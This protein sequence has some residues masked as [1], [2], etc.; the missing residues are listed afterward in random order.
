[1]R[2]RST[3]V[4]NSENASGQVVHFYDIE[5]RLS[6][7]ILSDL[8]YKETDLKARNLWQTVQTPQTTNYRAFVAFSRGLD[9]KDRGDYA[10]ARSQFQTALINDTNFELA[11]RE[12][13]HTPLAPLTIGQIES[14]IASQ[15]PAV[16]EAAGPPFAGVPI[17]SVPPVPI[18]APPVPAPPAVPAPAPPLP[19]PG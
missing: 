11:R 5:K 4:V 8:G 1:V 12:L 16:A 9:A 17:M 15:A 18:L 7:A 13:Y 10:E 3:A 14:Q 6:A 19:P 2:T